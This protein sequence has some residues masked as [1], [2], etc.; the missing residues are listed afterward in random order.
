[1]KFTSP[2]ILSLAVIGTM[3]TECRPIFYTSS[4]CTGSDTI[5]SIISGV[6]TGANPGL[7]LLMTPPAPTFQF[8]SAGYFL[9]YSLVLLIFFGSVS[10]RIISTR[11]LSFIWSTVNQ[12]ANLGTISSAIFSSALCV[13]L[14]W[15][16][17][18]EA[19][20]RYEISFSFFLSRDIFRAKRL[21]SALA[22]R[23]RGAGGRGGG[24]GAPG[25]AGAGGAGAGGAAGGGRG[26]G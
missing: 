19:W 1:M 16:R 22:S 8:R 14:V 2:G 3:I 10:F 11:R 15:P 24:R 5:I 4:R 20:F 26:A 25:R 9:R 21:V 13:S 6:I 17:F 7:P 12:L 18:D 23:A